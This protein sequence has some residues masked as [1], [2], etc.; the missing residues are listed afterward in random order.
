MIL[1][2]PSSLWA[3]DFCISSP[4][5]GWQSR[6]G[7]TQRKSSEWN[8]SDILY[9]SFRPS[10]YQLQQYSE[11][12]RRDES[13]IPSTRILYKQR[14]ILNQVQDDEYYYIMSFYVSFPLVEGG[15]GGSCISFLI[16]MTNMRIFIYFL[17]WI[18]P[19][20]LR[21]LPS[22]RELIRTIFWALLMFLLKGFH[23]SMGNIM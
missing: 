17:L 15:Y 8:E 9:P 19:L 1:E 23:V 14:K 12:H 4:L 20:F 11:S 13:W 21:H 6:G 16:C 18:H 22:I 5:E 7:A 2:I 10:G 3:G